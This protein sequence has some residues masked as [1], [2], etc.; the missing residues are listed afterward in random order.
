MRALLI[1]A[2]TVA[3]TALVPA[4]ADA[5]Q[6]VTIVGWTTA[7]IGDTPQV[8]NKKTIEQ[9]LDTGNG[10]RSLYVIYRGKGI[11]KNRKVGAAVWGGPPNAGFT[12][13][14]STADVTKAAF[15][16]PVGPKR[17]FTTRYGFSF[18]KGPF[19]PQDINGVW[20][21]KIVIKGKVVARATVTVAC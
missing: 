7:P 21:A 20:N 10:Q 16:W 17:S 3:G 4:A 15:K 8:K 19:G 9:C 13:E 5:K 1:T 14:P 12:A 11:D 6:T 18:A 2:V